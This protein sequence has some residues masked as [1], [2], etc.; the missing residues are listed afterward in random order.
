MTVLR[1]G[2]RGSRLALWQAHWVQRLLASVHRDVRVEIVPIETDGDRRTEA[3]LATLSGSAFFTKEIEGALLEGSI[4]LAVHSLKDVATEAPE[5][6]ILGAVL[7]RADPR[8][9]LVARDGHGLADLGE[10]ARVGTSS[11]RRKAFLRADHPGLV[12]RDVRGNVPTR[13]G[14]LDRG[15]ADA[16]LLACAGLDRLELGARITSRLDP[17]RFV[18]APAQGAVA[19][20]IRADDA[21]VRSRIAP[22]EH[23]PTRRA[24]DAERTFL[25]VLE[26]GCQVPLG[27][28]AQ[29]EGDSMRLVARVASLDGG[30][31]VRGALSGPSDDPDALGRTLA[32]RLIDEGAAD[33]LAE[34]RPS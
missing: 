27:A 9:A 29:V 26:G 16:L 12:T 28:F 10:G 32:R 34:L 25:N 20:Q 11:L 33:I 2:T 31:G 15:D 24:V 1:L 6:L 22:L 4:D 7:E 3:A 30:R 13:L 17:E 14:I 5:G 23:G 18:P 21:A 19:V 8:D